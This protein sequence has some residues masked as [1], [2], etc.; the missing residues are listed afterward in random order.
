MSSLI[1]FY[2]EPFWVGVYEKQNKNSYLVCKIVFGA[3]P[4]GNELYEFLLKNYSN[5]KFTKTTYS[6]ATATTK[7]NPKR[8]KRDVIKQMKI[9]GSSTKSQ[10]ALK[11]EYSKN[12]LEKRKKRKQQKEEAK[13]IKFKLHSEKR[14]EK[15]KGH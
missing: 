5:L 4:L 11:L 3:E 9:H 1:V 8:V 15:H 7:K 13:A 6:V 12:K 2:E 10:N 14:K